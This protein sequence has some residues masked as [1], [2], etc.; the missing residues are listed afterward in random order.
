MVVARAWDR[1]V[2]NKRVRAQRA[3]AQRE[4]EGRPP[5][6]GTRWSALQAISCMLHDRPPIGAEPG[7]QSRESRSSKLV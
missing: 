6:Q 5:R 1:D 3:A 7:R 4:S 2:R